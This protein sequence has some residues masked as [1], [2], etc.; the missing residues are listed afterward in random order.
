MGSVSVP[1][2]GGG[3]HLKLIKSC[4]NATYGSITVDV[5]NEL[6]N[7]NSYTKNDFAIWPKE[8]E[9]F[10][11]VI[12]GTIHPLPS[13]TGYSNGVLTITAGGKR[14]DSTQESSYWEYRTTKFDIY[15]V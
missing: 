13:I 5:K 12:S 8:A 4:T 7:Y 3:G 14:T 15:L 10:T 9:V 6:P 1:P 2:S 11:T